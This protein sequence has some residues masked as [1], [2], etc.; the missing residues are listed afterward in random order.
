MKVKII[1]KI[2]FRAAFI[3]CLCVLASGQIFGQSDCFD[4]NRGGG[5]TGDSNVGAVI[6][7]AAGI[8]ERRGFA[9]TPNCNAAIGS[10]RS[11]SLLIYGIE[12]KPGNNSDDQTLVEWLKE[13]DKNP[14]W[15]NKFR[16]GFTAADGMNFLKERFATAGDTWLGL[17]LDKWMNDIS[18]RA[19]AP[20]EKDYYV[21]RLKGKNETYASIFLAEK[22]KLNKNPAERKQMI[23]RAY[24]QAMGRN[25]TEGDLNYWQK[26]DEIYREIIAAS[27][28]YLYSP[29]GAKDLKETVTRAYQTKYKGSPLV[30]S[31]IAKLTADF[32]PAKMIYAEM[33]KK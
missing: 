20:A 33:I 4:Q 14:T 31:R 25:A 6:G 15:K 18:G 1:T 19:A 21:P 8:P 22:N 9:D 29:G 27:R 12:L 11:A 5:K 16:S 30:E 7:G 24:Q 3:F 13:I 28:A 2:I 17:Y 23:D 26:R 10:L 32:T